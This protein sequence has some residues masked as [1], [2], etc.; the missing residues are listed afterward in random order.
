M[1][2]YTRA[3][4]VGL[5]LCG[6]ELTIEACSILCNLYITHSISPISFSLAQASSLFVT[7]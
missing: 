6:Q 5:C 2:V 7:R 4:G 3:T 1:S